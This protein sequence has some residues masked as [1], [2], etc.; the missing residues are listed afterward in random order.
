MTN[1]Y[2]D[3]LLNDALLLP[4]HLYQAVLNIKQDY[5]AFV[6]SFQAQLYLHLLTFFVSY[7]A[8][9]QLDFFVQS[10]CYAN[11]VIK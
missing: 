4:I 3:L 8:F 11:S 1:Y 7:F 2:H 5:I 10:S 9:D 6:H